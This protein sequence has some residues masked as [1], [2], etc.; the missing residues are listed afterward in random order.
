MADYQGLQKGAWSGCRQII[1][2]G[3]RNMKKENQRF[4]LLNFGLILVACGVV[5]FKAPNHF[6]IGGVSG[7]SIIASYYFPK[8]NLG[9]FMFVINALFEVLALI[10]LGRKFAENTLYSSIVLSIFVWVLSALFPMDVP[11]TQDTMLELAFAIML[12][13]VGSAIVFN[14][15]S[16]TGGTDI[17]AKILNRYTCVDIGK[18]LFLSDVII[19]VFAGFIFGIRTG[20]YCGLGLVLKGTLVDVVIDGLKIRKVVTIISDK[21]EDILAYIMKHINRGATIYPAYGAFSGKPEKVIMTV[22]S[23]RQAMVLSNYIREVD[24]CAFITIENS[25]EI[26]GKGFSGQ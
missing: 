10:F 20:L 2:A 8:V 4:L 19:V 6:A 21:E 11:F 7:L 26:I 22:V 23:R 25:S 1:A 15:N 13:A 12:P 5:F 17:L 24:P 18:S 14:L 16:S 3:V 9:I